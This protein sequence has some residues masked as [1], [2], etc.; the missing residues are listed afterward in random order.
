MDVVNFISSK[1]ST[2][3]HVKVCMSSRPLPVFQNAFGKMQSL[4]LQ[5]L[6][7][8]SIRGYTRSRLLDIV[9]SQYLTPAPHSI[10][11]E[12]LIREVVARAEGVFLWVVIAVRSLREGLQG[13]V[14]PLELRKEIDRLPAGVESL[15]ARI[16]SRVKPMY[17]QGAARFLQIL[18]YEMDSV[19]GMT[20]L[21][22]LRLHL[23]YQQTDRG[24]VPLERFTPLDDQ[25]VDERC[26]QTMTQVSSHTLGLLDVIH[27]DFRPLHLAQV[28]MFH[29][30]TKDFLVRNDKAK[31]FLEAAGSEEYV[32]LS[33]ARGTFAYVMRRMERNQRLTL[34]AIKYYVDFA[35][36][37]ISCVENLT[38]SPQIELMES[39]HEFPFR[40]SA[41]LDIKVMDLEIPN[42][43]PSPAGPLF[44][45][46]ATAASH[47]M[48][49]LISEICG[50]SG[51]ASPTRLSE[52]PISYRGDG[53]ATL[54]LKWSADMVDSDSYQGQSLDEVLKWW[55]A[56]IIGPP[57]FCYRQQLGK[58]LQWCIDTQSI[59]QAPQKHIS[60]ALLLK[61]YFLACCVPTIYSHC[62]EET[63][64]IARRLLAAGAN[65]LVHIESSV[66]HLD[67]NPKA[68]SSGRSEIFW[69][70]WLKFLRKFSIIN[71][72]Y[73]STEMRDKLFEVTKAMLAQGAPVDYQIQYRNTFWLAYDPDSEHFRY[74]F[75]TLQRRSAMSYLKTCFCEISEFQEFMAA[76]ECTFKRP[77]SRIV[78][79][80]KIRK[81]PS[82]YHER[83]KRV[84]EICHPNKDE[85][86]F[87]LDLLGK[88]E[89]ELL[90]K[91]KIADVSEGS[92]G[93]DL[94]S[95]LEQIWQRH[96]RR[97]G[98][99][100]S[101]EIELTRSDDSVWEED[102]LE[103][104]W[105][106]EERD[107]SDKGL[108]PAE[109]GVPE[110]EDSS[111]EG[112][113][114]GGVYLP[115]VHSLSPPTSPVRP[116]KRQRS[117]GG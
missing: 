4:R 84:G 41:D 54:K 14:D 15:Y 13:C 57:S 51:F 1:L 31:A 45:I 65:P 86:D 44:D 59:Q 116:T 113:S 70:T 112:G 99:E 10:I 3:Q 107:A 50:L 114:Q 23:I 69:A 71:N 66:Y 46:V 97:P 100:G 34:D 85:N 105:P 102:S 20:N 61:S 63:I 73:K 16:L 96:Q 93:D 8:D 111:D 42:I 38:K 5:D 2:Q 9:Q 24:D 12:E 91:Y 81:K 52:C 101:A 95:G 72:R 79:F 80:Y 92:A 62:M 43:I 27:R 77:W 26:A 36:D 83:F 94:R 106:S 68:S 104:V 108:F 76:V 88:Y 56:P 60:E 103:A 25:K 75:R 64:E 115:E 55:C 89:I 47:G 11:T 39:I 98:I 32:R 28:R 49:L 87:L 30:T 110:E 58:A 67:P 19:Y 6:T 17:R 90:D 7:Y 35:L 21:D 74:A 78:R 18:I 48:V 53:G 117:A 33:I 22:I 82:N 29:K 109:G 37:Q 40:C